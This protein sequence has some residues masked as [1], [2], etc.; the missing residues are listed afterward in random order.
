MR[1]SR[2]P[3]GGREIGKRGGSFALG[4]PTFGPNPPKAVR[5]ALVQPH[6]GPPPP[7]G[8]LLLGQKYAEDPS[9]DVFLD[10]DGEATH[11]SRFL[12]QW[13]GVT[14]TWKRTING[15]DLPETPFAWLHN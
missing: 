7:L 15:K 2:P 1:G 10:L 5:L 13:D 11:L 4:G 12:C 8:H 9:Y 14:K 3:S 6:R